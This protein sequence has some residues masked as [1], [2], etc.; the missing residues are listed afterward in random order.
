MRFPE[1]LQAIKN[2]SVSYPEKAN[3]TIRED[4][5]YPRGISQ[6]L[7][8]RF[9]IDDCVST[10]TRAPL[11]IAYSACDMSSAVFPVLPFHCVDGDFYVR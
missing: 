9:F 7:H 6:F 11:R 1:V 4:L 10:Y 2:D 3:F 5:F 8:D